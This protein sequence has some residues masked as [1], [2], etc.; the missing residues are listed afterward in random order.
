MFLSAMEA[1]VVATA[2]PTVIAEL[3]GLALYGW[4]GA[5]YL[6]AS[7]VT[8]PLY[9]KLADRS[10]RKPVLLAGIAAMAGTLTNSASV[11]ATSPD[12]NPGDNA[13]SV[14][15]SVGAI[16]VPVSLP[17]LL[18][19]GGALAAAALALLRRA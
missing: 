3:G 2:M 19:F 13:A 6:L 18:L 4:V 7:T 9:G 10:G 17:F 14:V 15:T 1:T 8:V 11:A 16:A 5:A 12:P